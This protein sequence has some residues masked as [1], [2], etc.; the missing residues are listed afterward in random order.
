MCVAMLFEVLIGCKI[1]FKV[2][3][4]LMFDNEGAEQNCIDLLI[5]VIIVI[6]GI[7]VKLQCLKDFSVSRNVFMSNHNTF[8]IQIFV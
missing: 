7:L 8:T 3:I 2:V 1:L 6:H 5:L 4:V